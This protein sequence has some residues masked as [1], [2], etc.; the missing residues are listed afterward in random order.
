MKANTK[1]V[2]PFLTHMSEVFIKSFFTNLLR[3]INN[4][5]LFLMGLWISRAHT[6][7]GFVGGGVWLAETRGHII[8]AFLP[9]SCCCS[10]CK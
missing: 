1:R 7:E 6:G 2:C 9:S 4:G 8:L 10:F 3:G 5:V